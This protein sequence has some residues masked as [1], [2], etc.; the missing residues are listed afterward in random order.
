MRFHNETYNHQLPSNEARQDVDIQSVNLVF[1]GDCQRQSDIESAW[2]DAIKLVTT[3]P[4]I[5]FNDVAAVDFFGPPALNKD[6]QSKIQAVFDNAKTFGQGWKITPTPLKVQVN[7]GCGAN[8]DRELDSRCKGKG[9]GLKA[10]TWNTE[11]S[12]GTGKKNYNN[13]GATMNMYMCNS[14]FAYNSLADRIN[15]YKD[16]SDYT[17][18]YNMLYYTNRAYIILHE[19]MHANR[20][21]Y[22]ANGNRH[23]VDMN[24]KIYEYVRNPDDRGYKR[25][26]VSVDAYGS[27]N[28]KILARTSRKNIATDITLNADNFAQYVL[29]KYVQ[30][31]I[32]EY[33]WLPIAN[34]EAIGEVHPKIGQLILTNG[35]DWGL[36]GTNYENTLTDGGDDWNFTFSEDS[37]VDVSGLSDED[38]LAPLTDLEWTDD[39]QYPSDYIQQMKEWASKAPDMPTSTATPTPSQT[40]APPKP[41]NDL[42]CNGLG[43]KKYMSADT[44]AGNIKTFCQAA[45]AQGVQDKDSGSVSRNYNPRTLDEVDISVD[46]PSG[47]KIPFDEAECNKQLKA[48][49]DNCDGNDPANP[50]NWKGGGTTTIMST[51]PD[52]KVLYHIAPKSARQP[53]PNK[54]GGSCDVAYKFLYDEFWIWGNG[55]VTSDFGQQS[56][57]LMQQLKGCDGLTD[58]NFNYGLGDDGREW[59]ANGHLLIGKAGCVGRAIGSAGGPSGVDCSGST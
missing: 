22:E 6:Y 41:T 4:K 35:S 5:E 55:Y 27:Q 58:W 2:D 21:A 34:G 40:A 53:L 16:D 14:F 8:A 3:L 52:L 10:Y 56:N 36:F 42:H 25:R 18:K 29:S 50:M 39:D 17:H 19:M 46:W 26:L 37:T 24:M 44:L 1:S 32:G 20:I 15:E 23:I 7:V 13:K 57:G 11:N 54:P 30:G 38:T 43:S 45:V 48:T 31:E 28:T 49:S 33:P 12:D 51:N 9:P 47:V 59:S